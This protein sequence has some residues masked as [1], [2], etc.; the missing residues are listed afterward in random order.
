MLSLARLVEVRNRLYAQHSIGSVASQLPASSRSAEAHSTAY[1]RTGLPR[2]GEG[3]AGE[4]AGLRPLDER[5]PCGCHRGRA[6][7]QTSRGP[8]RCSKCA[9]ASRAQGSGRG[10]T[11][12]REC[13]AARRTSS[14]RPWSSGSR[15]ASTVASSGSRG[16]HSNAYCRSGPH[17]SVLPPTARF[18]SIAEGELRRRQLTEDGNVEISGRDLR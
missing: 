16:A 12:H 10:C 9:R 6:P 15:S 7:V 11:R 8:E 14:G 2:S 13:R 17:R 1:Y 3:G 5:S 18:E 4:R